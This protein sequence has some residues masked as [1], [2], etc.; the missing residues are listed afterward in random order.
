M[1]GAVRQ[2][3]S[4]AL[5]ASPTAA[6]RSAPIA[7]SSPICQVSGGLA[8]GT[9]LQSCTATQLH[10]QRGKI[11]A[12]TPVFTSSTKKPLHQHRPPSS[13]SLYCSQTQTVQQEEASRIIEAAQRAVTNFVIQRATF[14]PLDA[15]MHATRHARALLRPALETHLCQRHAT[16][17][18]SSVCR[19]HRLV[20]GAA[21]G[22]QNAGH[23]AT[24]A[25][26]TRSVAASAD[27]ATDGDAPAV[28]NKRAGKRKVALFIGY[29]GSEYRGKQLLLA[30]VCLLPACRPSAPPQNRETAKHMAAEFA[31]VA[32]NASLHDDALHMCLVCMMCRSADPAQQ[33]PRTNSRGLLRG[34]NLSSWR[35]TGIKPRQAQQG[36]RA[37]ACGSMFARACA[38]T[39]A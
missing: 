18:V 13:G 25:A 32:P 2:R 17:F 4:S 30:A 39:W 23:R 12:G 38:W 15:N 21:S 7:W 8:T 29:E 36:G 22:S 3:P 34:G 1:G 35:H 33:C 24:A 6:P 11:C 16:A 10:R 37:H 31:C 26:A 14:E 28:G 9:N 20:W 27:S 19:T 5:P